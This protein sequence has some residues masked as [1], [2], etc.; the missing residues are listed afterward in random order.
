MREILFRGKDYK[1]NWLYG[2]LVKK[3]FLQPNWEN[4]SEPNDIKNYSIV[5]K[6]EFAWDSK[7]DT[8]EVI[9]NT[10][11]QYTG[12][13]DENGKKIFEGDIVKFKNQIFRVVFEAGTFGIGSNNEVDYS[14]FDG[15]W[16]CNDYYISLYEIYSNYN[17]SYDDNMPLEVIGNIYDNPELLEVQDVKNS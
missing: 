8:T 12:L 3:T 1:G 14:N 4:L 16:I 11:G 9:E 13:K 15:I 17:I 2:S 5:H 10:I 6:P 7:Y